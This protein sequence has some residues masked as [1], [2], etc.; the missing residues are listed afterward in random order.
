MTRPVVALTIGDPA[1]IGPEIVL[2]AVKKKALNQRA[3]LLIIGDSFLLTDSTLPRSSSVLFS[4][5][6]FLRRNLEQQRFP[7]LLDCGHKPFTISCGRINKRCGQMSIDYVRTAVA[8]ALEGLVDGIVTA[9]INKRAWALA[10]TRYPGH[11]EMLA[12]L[13]HTRDFA[14]AF[15]AKGF[16]T[17]LLST[18]LP[19]RRAISTLRPGLLCDKV[20]LTAREL[21][22]LGIRH[23]RIAVAGLNP[24]AGEGGLLGKEEI[25]ILTPGIRR[26]QRER[27]AV[28]GPY[29]ADT[30]YLRA[31]AGEFDAVLAPY[32]DQAMVAVKSLSFGH[33]TN[34]TLGLPFVRTSVDHGTAFDIA[35]KGIADESALVEAIKRCVA[36]IGARRSA[37]E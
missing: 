30:L 27:I 12:A 6:A 1:G 20:R 18:H 14:M 37:R 17:V 19:L 35:G 29:S 3:R 24:H 31:A 26:C 5:P 33:A 7:Q 2:K 13:T 25:Q 21:S 36:L 11:T 34:I 32:H 22:A 8:L 23:P 10:G 28:S 16:Y 15:Y 9:P 4:A